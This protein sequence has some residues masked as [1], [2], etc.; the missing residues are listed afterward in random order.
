MGKDKTWDRAMVLL[1]AMR[2]GPIQVSSDEMDAAQILIDQDFVDTITVP[3][4]DELGGKKC[5]FDTAMKL[6]TKGH[7][8]LQ[9][10]DEEKSKKTVD[11]A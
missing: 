7:V 11:R 1:E 2:E 6:T 4:N 9:S 8:F 3:H 5:L 10:R